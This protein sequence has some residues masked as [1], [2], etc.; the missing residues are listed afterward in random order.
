MVF[1]K[2]LILHLNIL[3]I[4]YQ[5]I[6]WQGSSWNNEIVIQLKMIIFRVCL[7][8]YS[9]TFLVCFIYYYSINSHWYLYIIS[10]S[11][12]CERECSR[13]GFEQ[14]VTAKVSLQFPKLDR[15]RQ[16]NFQRTF[17]GN[18]GDKVGWLTDKLC[19]KF[20]KMQNRIKS[21]K[22]TVDFQNKLL[23]NFYAKN[24][25]VPLPTSQCYL[26]HLQTPECPQQSIL[27][28]LLLLS[29]QQL[30]ASPFV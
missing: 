25:R 10:F 17:C 15:L 2:L 8:Q 20:W 19:T 11:P 23:N 30:K 9:P 1:C 26:L 4:D 6:Q 28:S 29:F 3:Q 21:S 13:N 18:H 14:L 24:T 5:C 16:G 7:L 12:S 27:T 22:S